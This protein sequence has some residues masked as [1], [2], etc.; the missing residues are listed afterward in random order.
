MIIK[1]RLITV[2]LLLAIVACSKDD[3]D[4]TMPNSTN[5]NNNTDNTG[6]YKIEFT[7]DQNF[8][9][10]G[11]ADFS[12]FAR[13]T[14]V[15]INLDKAGG[16]TSEGIITI[17]SSNG[18]FMAQSLP[19]DAFANSLTHAAIIHENDTGLEFGCYSGTFEITGA[20]KANYINATF[21]G[22][23]RDLDTM[24]DTLQFTGTVN[25]KVRD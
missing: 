12:Q 13:D 23:A 24:E 11:E 9:V 16:S 10:E 25:T 19:A 8:T 2:I 20:E 21:Q 5:N 22:M 17:R 4:S 3:D 7:G 6:T 15:Q 1:S 14:F 18:V